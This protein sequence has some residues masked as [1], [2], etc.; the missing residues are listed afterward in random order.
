M[1]HTNLNF[2]DL[3]YRYGVF[4]FNRSRRPGVANFVPVGVYI[5]YSVQFEYAL[6][7]IQESGVYQYLMCRV[8]ENSK[9][10]NCVL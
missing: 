9:S 3:K 5:V 7:C 6:L 8:R 10:E 4:F 2:K 1:S